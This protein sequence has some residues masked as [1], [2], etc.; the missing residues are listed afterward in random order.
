[1]YVC[2]YECV[3]VCI[4]VYVHVYVCVW[5]CMYVCACVYVCVPGIENQGRESECHSHCLSQQAQLP[6]PQLQISETC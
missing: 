2:I 6:L 1:M 5:M 3:R 4:D